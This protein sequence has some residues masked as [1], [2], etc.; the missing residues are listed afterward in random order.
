M[1]E[2]ADT[3]NTERLPVSVLTGFL[4]SGKTTLLRRALASTDFADTAVI[5]NE[6]G[7]IAIQG[8]A[9]VPRQRRARAVPIGRIAH[10]EL[11]RGPG[12]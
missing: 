2:A 6:V 5:I 4:G 3:G 9:E 1:S 10:F 11:G 7:A 8:K 12:E